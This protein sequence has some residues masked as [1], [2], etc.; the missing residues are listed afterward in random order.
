MPLSEPIQDTKSMMQDEK[1]KTP[2]HRE[3]SRLESRSHTGG[4]VS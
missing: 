4:P 1:Q 3:D 2:I